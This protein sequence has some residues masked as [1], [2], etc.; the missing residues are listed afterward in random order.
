MDFRVVKIDV[1]EKLKAGKVIRQASFAP[2]TTGCRKH[3]SQ[4][5]RRPQAKYRPA[6][7]LHKQQVGAEGLKGTINLFPF[8]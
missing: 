3:R 1:G 2:L 5:L 6:N 8:F 4:C 7:G